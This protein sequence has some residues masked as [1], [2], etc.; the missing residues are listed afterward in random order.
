MTRADAA[1][2]YF[3][4]HKDFMDTRVNSGIE[5]H[6]KGD[7]TITFKASNGEL[8]RDITIEVR[9]KNH[10]FKFGCNLFMLDEFESAEKNALYREK[11]PECF[12]IATIPFYWSD[13][14]P[15]QGK[16]R[17][18]A[19]SPKIYRRPA[20]DLCLNYCKDSKVEPKCHCL[21]YDNFVP[22]W[23]R[24]QP[25]AQQKILLE[26]RFKEIA[27]RYADKIPSFEVTN[28]TLQGDRPNRKQT[29]FFFEDDFVDWSFRMA[30]KYFPHNHLIIN[31]YN[32]WAPETFNNRTMYYMQIADLQRRG[33][34]NIDSIGMQYHCFFADVDVEAD[35]ASTVYNPENIYRLLDL[36]GKFGIAEQITEMTVPA[37]GETDEE[38]EWVQAELIKNLY[39]IFFSHPAMEAVIY[40][41]LV[42]GY[43]AF[44]PQGDMTSGENRFRGGLLRF[45]MSEKPAY[46]MLKQLIN[47]TWHTETTVK[48]NGNTAKFRGFYGDYELIVHADGKTIPVDWTF[49]SKSSHA[50]T[51]EL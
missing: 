46:K 48:A 27:E 3:R 22:A 29:P 14:E 35:R 5:L 31:D 41:N 1:L 32:I 49:A 20:I 43:A 23:Y 34:H 6:R 8:P 36:Y 51:I 12:N 45:D 19:D 10:E 26:K 47:E 17:F 50:L 38:G 21:N 11:F 37:L 39:S 9:Q 24:D 15:E 13:L 40:W 33:I 4:E 42:D 28:E 16:P 18:A 44:A 25:I 7:A 30:E 2:K